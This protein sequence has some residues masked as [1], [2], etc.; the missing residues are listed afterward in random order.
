[1]KPTT[2]NVQITKCPKQYEAVRLGMECTI[3]A[4][5]TVESAIKAAT[6]QLTAIYEGMINPQAK[7]AAAPAA[8]A[9]PAPEPA[10]EP[11]RERLEFGDKRV[12]QIVRR[13]EKTPEKAQDIMAQTLKYFEPTEEV[14]NVLKLAA[15]IV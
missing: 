13:M 14:L 7:P 4:G 1:M 12:Q 9:A 2:I 6:E 10:K 11:T 15:K 8:P 3:D 5:E